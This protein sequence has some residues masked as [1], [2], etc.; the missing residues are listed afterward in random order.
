[1]HEE[2]LQKENKFRN[3]ETDEEE[4]EFNDDEGYDGGYDGGCDEKDY[5]LPYDDEKLNEFE[6]MVLYSEME[7][8]IAH[9]EQYIKPLHVKFGS[10]S[11]PKQVLLYSIPHLSFFDEN[12]GLVF[13]NPFL[14]T[15]VWA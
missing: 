5:I 2:Y 15:T 6:D 14:G 12:L 9:Y 3:E 13:T 8:Y 1:M 10:R 4:L 11:D 7:D